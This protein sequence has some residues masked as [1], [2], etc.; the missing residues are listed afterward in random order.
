VF[1]ANY[2]QRIPKVANMSRQE[3]KQWASSSTS[4]RSTKP[5]CR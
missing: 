4:G 5:V 2:A 3:F 1:C